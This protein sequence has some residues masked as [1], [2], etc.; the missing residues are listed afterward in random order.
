MAKPVYHSSIEGAQ[1]GG[2]GLEGF[3]VNCFFKFQKIFVEQIMFAMISNFHFVGLFH[4][5]LNAFNIQI[6]KSHKSW[7]IDFDKGSIREPGRWEQSNLN[8]L[9]ASL[10]KISKVGK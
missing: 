4:A 5:D 3:C 7:L 9:K 10:E 1:H 6:D 8:R 2:K